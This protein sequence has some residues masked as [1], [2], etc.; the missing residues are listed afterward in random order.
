LRLFPAPSSA[1]TVR[2][3]AVCSPTYLTH[4]DLSTS[5]A[6]PCSEEAATAYILPTA[7][8]RL[9]ASPDFARPDLTP[10]I[11]RNADAATLWLSLR[12]RH[13]APTNALIGTPR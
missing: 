10:A 9:T 7:I 5:T 6:L 13:Q 3:S 4:A 1:C 11:L 8:A 12:P 2:F